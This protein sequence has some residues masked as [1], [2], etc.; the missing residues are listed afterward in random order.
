MSIVIR[1]ITKAFGKQIVLNNLSLEIKKGEFHVILGPSGEGKSTFL[2]II[3][4][5]M[6]PD[7][8]NIWIEGQLV[9][10][11]S[12]QK[13]EVGFV[14][15]DYALFPH[16]TVYEN[17]AYGLRAKG[18]KEKV[19]RK[20]VFRY[21]EL[22][23]LM[24]YQNKYLIALSGGQKQRVALARALATEPKV[25]LLDEPLSHLDPHLQEQ[26]MDELKDIQRKTAVTTLYVTHN[27]AEAIVL[28][29]RISVLYQGHIEQVGEPAEVFYRPKTPFVAK[30]VGATNVL[31]VRL[32]EVNDERAKF[33]IVHPELKKVLEIIVL[34]YPIFNRK[35]T[36]SLCLHPEKIK[37]CQEP[38]E[39]NSFLG[40]VLKVENQ[41]PILQVTVDIWGLRLKVVL[42]KVMFGALNKEIWVCF[43]PDA[44]HPLCGRCYRLPIHL[45]ECKQQKNKR[46]GLNEVTLSPTCSI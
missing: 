41:G 33:R 15:Q 29:D 25:L 46:R 34:K 11:L 43:P 4:G 3:A 22:V 19:I 1:N 6:K 45:R 44:L 40:T 35:K 14:F 21:L 26:L 8:G 5:L 10:K 20:K 18:L 27:Q 28:G 17:V 30:F 9:N 7:K 36:L 24:T 42:P 38:K 32:L 39:V 31:N 13:R 16:L 37:L 23:G 12:P 2:N